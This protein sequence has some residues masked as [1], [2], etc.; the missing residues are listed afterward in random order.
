MRLFEE[1][2]TDRQ[3]K[4]DDSSTED[5]GQEVR[6]RLE[7]GALEPVHGVGWLREN[8]AKEPADN[9]T[10]KGGQLQFT[11]CE[12]QEKDQRLTPGTTQ[13]A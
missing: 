12:A 5:V 7:D 13:T 1:Q 8:T 9:G 6:V 4:D 11:A 2:D 3:A 10:T